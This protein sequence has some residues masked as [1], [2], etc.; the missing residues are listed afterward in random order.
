MAKPLGGQAIPA[1]YQLTGCTTEPTLQTPTDTSVD[2]VLP[3]CNVLVFFFNILCALGNHNSGKIIHSLSP[4]NKY[5][6]FSVF[7]QVN[8]EKKFVFL[9][10]SIVIEGLCGCIAN[11][12]DT[13]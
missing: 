4:Y 2:E 10:F 3:S 7:C 9:W 13:K 11:A 5:N 12:P 6:T 8:C 1:L